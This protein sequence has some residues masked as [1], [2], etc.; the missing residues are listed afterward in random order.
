MA[1]NF[2]QSFSYL[3]SLLNAIENRMHQVKRIPQLPAFIFILFLRRLYR[4]FYWLLLLDKLHICNGTTSGMLF[5]GVANRVLNRG[6]GRAR[7][8][9]FRT[10]LSFRI[11][12]RDIFESQPTSL[13]T[14]ISSF[15]LNL[16]H[17][18]FSIN[19]ITPI[20]VFFSILLISIFLNKL[21]KV[22]QRLQMSIVQ[23]ICP[24]RIL[25]LSK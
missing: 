5:F 17:G 1:F 13:S 11:N 4:L 19:M 3:V 14:E 6:L 10:L 15:K 23:F 7:F 22:M 16:F 20:S 18:R 21:F 9:S 24:G 2:T 25:D 8:G 12:S